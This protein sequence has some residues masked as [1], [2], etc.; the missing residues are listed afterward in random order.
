MA[1]RRTFSSPPLQAGQPGSDTDD[2][3]ASS[4]SSSA[5]SSRRGSRS[6][7]GSLGDLSGNT[8]GVLLTRKIDGLSSS[9]GENICTSPY[10]PTSPSFATN[11]ESDNEEDKLIPSPSPNYSE[12]LISDVQW[13]ELLNSGPVDIH[14]LSE[15]SRDTLPNPAVDFPD[16]SADISNFIP[17]TPGGNDLSTAV[18]LP[19]TVER[20]Q[21]RRPSLESSG[22]DLESRENNLGLGA[23][24]PIK[25]APKRRL[26]R[27]SNETESAFKEPFKDSFKEKFPQQ[28]EKVFSAY[29][30]STSGL[31]SKEE[32][33]QQKMLW[34]YWLLPTQ[35]C[36]NI[37]AF[38]TSYQI[39]AEKGIVLDKHNTE[40]ILTA[41][42]ELGN[43]EV[44]DE[45]II[46]D[47]INRQ[48]KL[49]DFL[50][51]NPILQ[52]Q[53]RETASLFDDIVSDI[54]KLTGATV[55]ADQ[56]WR[57]CVN[58]ALVG[59]AIKAGISP[60]NPLLCFISNS[61]DNPYLFN[62]AKGWQRIVSAGLKDEKLSADLL[63]S[64]YE[65]CTGAENKVPFMEDLDNGNECALVMGS[66]MTDEGLSLLEKNIENSY[67]DYGIKVTYKLSM[68]K[69][70]G[71]QVV[72]LKRAAMDPNDLKEA[73]KDFVI[74]YFK[75]DK[76]IT[77]S[78]ANSLEDKAQR[79]TM[80]DLNLAR[81]LT[82][83][84]IFPSGNTMVGHLLINFLRLKRRQSPASLVN[85]DDIDGSHDKKFQKNFIENMNDLVT[86]S[87]NNFIKRA[88][89]SVR[90]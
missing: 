47:G 38:K 6:S 52:F 20:S 90:R 10:N 89:S 12:F 46:E 3:G 19:G 77:D 44:G 55:E 75:E 16:M 60:D 61:P 22:S 41:L 4:S 27:A 51:K 63:I 84:R 2:L 58:P 69:D 72:D 28:L 18:E 34:K 37:A 5:T 88:D 30:T 65:T 8:P 82:Q 23:P 53:T 29:K 7:T 13:E 86:E 50:N 70:F 15:N 40:K 14:L 49:G 21:K 42:A 25:R 36:V 59:N 64:L 78:G 68:D 43:L 57:Y 87:E 66:N 73:L 45:K 31:T 76:K 71:K 26:T 62:M 56:M 54:K 33:H 85:Y 24:S 74:E 17:S 48:A 83:H 80:N 81:K 1:I 39:C 67:Q 11:A 9:R 32:K 79:R 35:E